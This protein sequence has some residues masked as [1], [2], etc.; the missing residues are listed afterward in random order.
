MAAVQ[1]I[2]M[3]PKGIQFACEFLAIRIEFYELIHGHLDLLIFVVNRDCHFEVAV[4][5]T[6]IRLT[7]DFKGRSPAI[8][9]ANQ[10]LLAVTRG[11][12][13]AFF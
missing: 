7:V 13:R 11:E 3:V 10:H 5:E 9:L 4:V 8:V 12:M 1:S 6:P 2:E